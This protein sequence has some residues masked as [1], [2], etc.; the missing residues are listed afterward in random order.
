MSPFIWDISQLL[1]MFTSREICKRMPKS[2][3]CVF[4]K[5]P[6]ETNFFS[7]WSRKITCLFPIGWEINLLFLHWFGRNPTFSY[8]SETFIVL[9]LSI[10]KPTVLKNMEFSKRQ[11]N[12]FS[13]QIYRERWQVRREGVNRF[14]YNPRGW[15]ER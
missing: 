3:S 8:W 13:S 6:V 14:I 11:I 1:E 4:L 12:T 10:E 2:Y 9:T 7:Y 15:W 5:H